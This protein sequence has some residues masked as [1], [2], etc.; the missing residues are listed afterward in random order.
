MATSKV[1][2]LRCDYPGCDQTAVTEATT[3]A[4]ARA[5]VSWAHDRQRKADLCPLH[6]QPAQG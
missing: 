2:R 4:A 3:P 1:I 6:P 5:S